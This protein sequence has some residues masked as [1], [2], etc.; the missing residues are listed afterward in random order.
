MRFGTLEHE[1]EH[2]VLPQC[3]NKAKQ[4]AAQTIDTL[5]E[6]TLMQFAS[7]KHD[8]DLFPNLDQAIKACLVRFIIWKVKN[9][10][11]CLPDDFVLTEDA[12]THQRG[13][14]LEAKL[15]SLMSAEERISHIEDAFSINVVQPFSTGLQAQQAPAS[16]PSSS[17]PPVSLS[18]MFRLQPPP[19]M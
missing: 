18:Q 8:P 6:Q 10:P 13:L 15:H 14:M 9:E 1:L 16:A 2:K 17:A 3:V 11:P 4:V 7:G 12:Q 5:Q 19:R